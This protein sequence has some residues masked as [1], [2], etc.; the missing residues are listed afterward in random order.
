[1]TIRDFFVAPAYF[2]GEW[3]ASRRWPSLVRAAPAIVVAGLLAC[4][5]IIHRTASQSARQSAIVQT[6]NTA[7][8]DQNFE[9][10][11]FLYGKALRNEPQSHMLAFRRA[12]AI[13]GVGNHEL[14]EKQMLGLAPP[15]GVDGLADAHKWFIQKYISDAATPETETL[16]RQHS[17]RLLEHEPGNVQAHWVLVNHAMQTANLKSA[18]EHFPSV[19]EQMPAV[20]I[21]YAKALYTAGDRSRAHQQAGK[22]VTYIRSEFEKTPDALREVNFFVD[23]AAAHAIRDEYRMAI[24]V[25]NSGARQAAAAKQDQAPYHQAAAQITVAWTMHLER[26]D[27]DSVKTQFELLGNAIQ[28]NPNDA[29]LLARIAQLAGAVDSQDGIA[30]DALHTAL[31]EGT[32]PPLVHFLL[33][34]QA[35]L[36]NDAS[37]ARRHLERAI[38]M[39]PRALASLNNLAWTIA[40]A[41]P[42]DLPG[43]LRLVDEAIAI[44]PTHAQVRDTR[45]QILVLMQRWPEAIDELELALRELNGE[46]HIHRAL[47]LAYQHIGEP[48]LSKLHAEKAGGAATEAKS[49]A[50]DKT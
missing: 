49:D 33:G 24:R 26:T 14:A 27:P 39:Q 3:L 21:R 42:A 8:S 44:A 37:T 10:A 28:L 47:S 6:A 50:V 30:T 12:L 9:Y 31:A 5:W 15:D 36:K 34:T 25:L 19:V 2:A 35:A 23:W 16:L 48:A 29:S 1:M 38:K 45:G 46:P 32:A 13:D 18:L 11:E 40:H 20:R 17:E 7:Y 43:A 22:S 4:G 41:D